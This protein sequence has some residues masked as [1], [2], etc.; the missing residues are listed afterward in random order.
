MGKGR[1]L[2]KSIEAGLTL[3]QDVFQTKK[4]ERYVVAV[5]C[6]GI[7]VHKEMQS[8]YAWGMVALELL[9]KASGKDKS[10]TALPEV[11]LDVRVESEMRQAGKAANK[12]GVYNN[13]AWRASGSTTEKYQ[14]FRQ[15]ND[16]TAFPY[17]KELF[18]LKGA[19]SILPPAVYGANVK[20]ICGTRQQVYDRGY[21]PTTS[22]KD[23]VNAGLA[24][25][26]QEATTKKKEEKDIDDLE[27]KVEAA[28][29]AVK[30][31][32]TKAKMAV[33][34]E[35]QQEAH[36][37]AAVAEKDLH[38]LQI[39][40]DEKLESAD[41][42]LAEYDAEVVVRVLFD[43]LAECQVKKPIVDGEDVTHVEQAK[44]LRKHT[45]GSLFGGRKCTDISEISR[46]TKRENGT[47]MGAWMGGMSP[48]GTRREVIIGV[49]D[50]N[51]WLHQ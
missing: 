29:H 11:V 8:E 7:D 15:T 37:E 18:E 49:L 47:V 2:R 40:L 51:P 3:H 22:F 38:A 36:V 5:P 20:M 31:A 41:I 50:L 9:E 39:E 43:D 16:A 45:D 6:D 30:Q 42:S 14:Q 24:A 17:T 13:L 12:W 32:E 28:E 21:V 26:K 35:K 19:G 34:E 33:G 10:F 44:E 4:L 46:N 23:C 48:E 1:W 25:V 27:K